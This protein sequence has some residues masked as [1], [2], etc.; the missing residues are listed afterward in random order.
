MDNLI[1]YC[2][3]GKFNKH[4]LYKYVME[5]LQENKNSREPDL[6]IDS[7]INYMVTSDET[8][9]FKLC[10]DICITLLLTTSRNVVE[11]NRSINI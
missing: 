8:T 4:E 3:Y 6:D 9:K 10:K 2:K 11:N 5:Y 7:V 1:N